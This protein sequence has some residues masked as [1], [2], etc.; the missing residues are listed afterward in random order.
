[1]MKHSA[2]LAAVSLTL[3]ACDQQE[4]SPVDSKVSPTSGLDNEQ[5]LSGTRSLADETATGPTRARD[6]EAAIRIPARFH[7]VW[8]HVEA[9]CAQASETRL[10]IAPG[11]I[12][13]YESFGRVTGVVQESEAVIVDLAME[14][15]GE[16]WTN[17]QRLEL[18]EE[19][20]RT[21]LQTDSGSQPQERDGFPRR[22]CG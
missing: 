14:G 10:E 19:G 18:V 21:L 3:G 2:A 9:T 12:T 11:S 1:M 16:R 15:E 22:K 6:S 17:V 8:D 20:G 4:A 7:G 5:T 13:F